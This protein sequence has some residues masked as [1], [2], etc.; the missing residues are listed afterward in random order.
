LGDAWRWSLRRKRTEDDDLALF[1]RQAIRWLVAD[2]P[3]R[4][5]IEVQPNATSTEYK[6]FVTTR[7][8]EFEP[9]DAAVVELTVTQPGN[10]EPI[11]LTAEPSGERVGVYEASFAPRTAGGYRVEAK[12]TAADGENLLPAEAGWVSAPAEREFEQLRVNTRRLSELAERSEGT[13]VS[14][15]RIDQLTELLESRPAPVTEQWV[16]PLWHRGWVL[17]L[18]VFCLCGE[19]GIRRWK[20]MA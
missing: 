9:D 4:A 15:D 1:W 11:Q 13:S 7:T 12:V 5:E 10:D 18:T 19:W 3:K 8:V 20:G 17:G 2:V 6:I 14:P 16:A